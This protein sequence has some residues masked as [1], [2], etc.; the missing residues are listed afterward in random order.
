MILAHNEIISE[1]GKNRV[2]IE[3]FAEE[4]V[5]P[6]SYDVRLGDTLKM[7]VPNTIPNL[8][9]FGR[10]EGVRY[11][12]PREEQVAYELADTGGGWLLHPG[13]LYLGSTIEAIGSDHY[14]P[15]LVGRSSIA[16]MGLTVELSAGLGDVGFK[17]QWTLE[18]TCVLPILLTPGMRI[19]QVYFHKVSSNDCLYKGRYANQ[20]G[21]TASRY[22]Q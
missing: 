16:R 5:G 2:V 14:V 7:V 20:Q 15:M 11:I 18:I 10:Q 12:D 21:P 4:F 1:R 13:E 3:P 8:M 17:S 22:N 19:A 9:L 6:N